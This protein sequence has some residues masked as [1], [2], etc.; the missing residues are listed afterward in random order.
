MTDWVFRKTAGFGKV[1]VE[2]RGIYPA[3]AVPGEAL[4][5][6]LK[7]RTGGTWR[8]IYIKE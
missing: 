3:E 8:Y 2:I 4:L 5:A 7:D 1:F 6:A